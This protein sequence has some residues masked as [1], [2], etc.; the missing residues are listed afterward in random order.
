MATIV[1]TL[2][3]TN[4]IL[5]VCTIDSRKLARIFLLRILVRLKEI[6]TLILIEKTIPSTVNRVCKTITLPF[7]P[8]IDSRQATI[9]TDTIRIII[10]P[11]FLL[12]YLA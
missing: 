3:S 1:D 11:I 9:T 12:L 8:A 4:N 7:T 6:K 5:R 10:L 2:K